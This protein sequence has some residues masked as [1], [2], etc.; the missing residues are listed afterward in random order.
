MKLDISA[1]FLVLLQSAPGGFA[2]TFF[3]QILLIIAIFYFLVFRPQAKQR[4]SHE[5]ALK[6]LKR[7]DRIVTTGGIIG[8]VVHIRETTKDGAP[9]PT[10][11]DEVTIK[12]GESRLVVERGRIAKIVS[13]TAP[14]ATS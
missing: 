12:S 14:A 13:A 1:A 5:D 7:G 11:D 4:K 10:M 6:N 3:I 2:N 9:A 8:D